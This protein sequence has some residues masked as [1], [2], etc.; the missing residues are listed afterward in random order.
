M[1]RLPRY[2]QL[3][4]EFDR[5]LNTYIKRCHGNRLCRRVRSDARRALAQTLFTGRTPKK[6]VP[7]GRV[8]SLLAEIGKEIVE[9][10]YSLPRAWYE[11]CAY[12]TSKSTLVSRWKVHRYEIRDLES[13]WDDL[14]YTMQEYLALIEKSGAAWRFEVDEMHEDLTLVLDEKA[15][16]DILLLALEAYAV[17]KGRGSTFTEVYGICFGSTRSNEEKRRG[18]GKHTSRH[19]R[20]RSVRTQIRAEGFSDRI[21]YDFRSLDAQMMVMNYLMPAFDIVADFHTH[22]YEDVREL[23]RMGGWR[24]SR[25]DESTMP[26]WVAQLKSKQYHPRASLILA[27]AKGKRKIGRPG[28]IRPNLVRFSIGKYHF[29]LAAYRISGD[30]YSDTGISINADALPGI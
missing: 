11:H 16:E 18:H 9:D 23:V 5:R 30:Q 8:S 29:Y 25:A 27:V 21:T 1:P 19:I 4:E 2:S 3:I 12:Q 20:V 10:E 6:N 15:I 17:P 22:P 7:R 13:L 28:K 24:F 14:D 26:A